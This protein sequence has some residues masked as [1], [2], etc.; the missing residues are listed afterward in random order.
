MFSNRIGTKFPNICIQDLHEITNAQFYK[1]TALISKAPMITEVV[2]E[3]ILC[4]CSGG[5]SELVELEDGASDVVFVKVPFVPAL[6]SKY[7]QRKE[8]QENI[9]MEDEEIWDNINQKDLI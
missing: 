9:Q 5:L 7:K 6:S 4:R 8:T 2:K 1:K 3:L